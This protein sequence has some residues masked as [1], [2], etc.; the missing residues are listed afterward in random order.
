ML[1]E[2]TDDQTVLTS[3][4]EV[5]EEEWKDLENRFEHIA[6]DAFVIVTNHLHAIVHLVGATL[7][8]AQTGGTSAG[9]GSCSV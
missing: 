7:A 3:Y 4:G 5:V 6:L 2:I 1:S 8:A 9:A